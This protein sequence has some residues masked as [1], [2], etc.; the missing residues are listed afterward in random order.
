MISVQG[1]K[2]VSGEEIIGRVDDRVSMVA[3][4]KYVIERPRVL[5]PQQMGNGQISLGMAPWIISAGEDATHE[6]SP[7]AV[8]SGPFDVMKNIETEYL[9]QTTG[10]QL[11]TG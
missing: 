3:S 2:L 8:A 7:D 11:V 5:I 9:R 10:I 6:I 1:F 4:D